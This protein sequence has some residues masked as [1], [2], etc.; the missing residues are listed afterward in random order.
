VKRLHHVNLLGVIAVAV[1]C[2]VQWQRNRHLSLEVN[3]AEK[4]QLEQVERIGE[5][6]QMLLGLKADLAQFKEQVTK[7]RNELSDGRQKLQAAEREQLKSSIT[8]WASAVGERDERLKEADVQIRRLAEE[9]NS[10]VLKFNELAT[11][12]NAVVKELNELRARSAQPPT[13][14]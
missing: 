12:H 8:N 13:S 3:R 4:I 14:K 6:E 10:S 1:L 9:L 2:V 5:R 11:N 7:S